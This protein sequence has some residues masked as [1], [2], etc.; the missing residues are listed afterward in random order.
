ML[1]RLVRRQQQQGDRAR[2]RDLRRDGEDAPEAPVREARRL[3][4]RAGGRDRAAPAADRLTLS[5]D[6][7]TRSIPPIGRLSRDRLCARTAAQNGDAQRRSS[8]AGTRSSSAAASPA[9]SR[10]RRSRAHFARV[11]LVER[12]RYPDAPDTRKGTPQ[13]R[14][15]HVLLKQGEA[16]IERLFPGLFDELVAD[17]GQRVDIAGD[18]RW[19]YFGDWKARFTSGI[20]MVSQSR[21]LLEWKLR[22]RV[23]ALAERPSSSR[24]TCP[25]S[26][27]TRR[28]RVAACA[29]AARGGDARRRRSPPTSSS[30][31]AA[32][33]R[34]CRSGSRSSAVGRPPESEVR[35]DVGYATRFYRRTDAAARLDGAALPPAAARTRAAACSCR[36]RTSAGC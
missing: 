17:G 19:H 10:P 15:V 27:R 14:H 36:S 31:R 11:T 2:A 20:E 21:A 30:T 23:A 8:A 6:R 22:R 25:A 28:A 24:A 7:G 12:D 1:E 35:V 33:A 9:S 26:P 13:A 34:A 32:A 4:P 16:A 3:R 5:P 18:A 29:C